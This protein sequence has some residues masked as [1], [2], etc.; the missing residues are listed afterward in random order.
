MTNLAAGSAGDM[1]SSSSAANT[2]SGGASAETCAQGTD[3]GL[4][5]DSESF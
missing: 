5:T 3:S 2:V 1:L 4:N